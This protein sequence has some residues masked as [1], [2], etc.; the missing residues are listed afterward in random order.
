VQ[1]VRTS[2]TQC[3]ESEARFA[4]RKIALRALMLHL[5][6]DDCI[7]LNHAGD[8]MVKLLACCL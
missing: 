6:S 2:L 1:L 8:E 3:R 7:G 4:R 5:A